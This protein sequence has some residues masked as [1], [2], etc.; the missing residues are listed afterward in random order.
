M[1]TNVRDTF[2]AQHIAV[3]IFHRWV[4]NR[5]PFASRGVEHGETALEKRQAL[6]RRQA[7]VIR[8]ILPNSTL[9]RRTS[10][11]AKNNTV[12][13]DDRGVS[14]PRCRRHSGGDEPLPSQ[15]SV[16]WAHIELPHVVENLGY[17]TTTKNIQRRTDETRGLTRARRWSRRT[18]TV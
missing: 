8:G 16:C 7:F 1:F 15:A 2:T 12:A 6:H 5:K 14:N 18:D 3:R 11:T 9:S 17:V 10:S 4:L 13:Q